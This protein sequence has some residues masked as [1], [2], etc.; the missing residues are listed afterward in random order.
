MQRR[1]RF[2]PAPWFTGDPAP[3]TVRALDSTYAGAFTAGA[4]RVAVDTTTTGGATAIGTFPNT[5]ERA[6]TPPDAGEMLDWVLVLDDAARG[7][8][9]PGTRVPR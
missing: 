2:L 4:T 7:Y 1:I 6:F 8:P 3:L 5:G 9:A